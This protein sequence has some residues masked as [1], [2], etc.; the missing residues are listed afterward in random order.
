[1]V[2]IHGDLRISNAGESNK[3]DDGLDE[4]HFGE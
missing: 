1:M 2:V 4:T 3:R